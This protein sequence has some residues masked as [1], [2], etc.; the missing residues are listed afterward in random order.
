MTDAPS[1]IVAGKRAVSGGTHRSEETIDLMAQLIGL[2]R[3]GTG[4]RPDIIRHASALD[5]G[6]RHTDDV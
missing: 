3:E 1:R 6:I 5:D 2:L 4:G